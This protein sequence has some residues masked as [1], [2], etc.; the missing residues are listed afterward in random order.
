MHMDGKKHTDSKP[1]TTNQDEKV[2]LQKIT[3]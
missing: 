2:E 3:S 1:E